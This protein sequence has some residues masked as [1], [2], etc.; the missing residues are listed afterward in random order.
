V[1]VIADRI[2]EIVELGLAPRLKRAGYRKSGRTFRHIAGPATKVTNLQGSWTNQG[3]EGRFT[4]N[5]G[6]YFPEAARLHGLFPVT[7]QPLESHCVVHARIG[8][9]MPVHRDFWWKVTDGSSLTDLSLEVGEAWERYGKPW[10]DEHTD[11]LKARDFMQR[12]GMPFWSAIFSIIAGDRAGASTF[13]E[14]ALH[15]AARNPE[16]S[17]TI[18][19]WGRQQSLL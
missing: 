4:I 14:Q 5:L 16:L 3:S 15:E 9:L 10:L 8:S 12:L 13:L 7:Q 18:R 1:S 19:K 17:A 11:V 2:D 6:V